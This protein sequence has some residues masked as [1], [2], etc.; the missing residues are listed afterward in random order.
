MPSRFL[1]QT[2]DADTW[3]TSGLKRSH[4]DE[5]SKLTESLVTVS[6]WA[7]TFLR[8]YSILGSHATEKAMKWD[9]VY[10][11][12]KRMPLFPH[13]TSHF[14]QKIKENKSS[15]L[16]SYSYLL[17]KDGA[18]SQAA[19]IQAQIRAVK[20]HPQPVPRASYLASCQDETGICGFSP[21]SAKALLPKQCCLPHTQLNTA[22]L[23]DSFLPGGIYRLVTL[24]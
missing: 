18:A 5:E 17:Q 2:L 8:C 13:L 4:K 1:S 21:S 3:H 11:P 24:P 6:K 23:A 20:E 22:T 15:L 7:F 12:L 19:L 10:T 14:V 9:I 16:C